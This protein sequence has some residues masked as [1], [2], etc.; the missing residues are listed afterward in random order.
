[1]EK[2]DPACISV[3]QSEWDGCIASNLAQIRLG[4]LF[5]DENQYTYTGGEVRIVSKSQLEAIHSKPRKLLDR[6]LSVE[7]GLRILDIFILQVRSLSKF[8]RLY[9][10][11]SN[12]SLQ[13]N[14]TVGARHRRNPEFHGTDFCSVC[15][16]AVMCSGLLP[17]SP[18]LEYIAK[19]MAI[20]TTQFATNGVYRTAAA[21][22]AEH[23]PWEHLFDMIQP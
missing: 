6:I 16:S 3:K 7:V 15:Q 10:L 21:S 14:L 4:D 18:Q 9:R 8:S 22:L 5:V 13:H 12:W 11:F 19:L 1:L 23:R 2:L 17:E 20:K